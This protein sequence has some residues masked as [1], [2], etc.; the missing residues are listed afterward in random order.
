LLSDPPDGP[1]QPPELPFQGLLIPGFEDFSSADLDRD[2]AV[3]NIITEVNNLFL[4]KNRIFLA[5]RGVE[6]GP[7]DSCFT[8]V[9][10]Q[11][12]EG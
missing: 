2:P 9:N 6:R 12:K 10:T 7:H 3:I 1:F 5:L 4:L 11:E 8:G